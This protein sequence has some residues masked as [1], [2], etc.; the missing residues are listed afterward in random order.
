[1]IEGYWTTTGLQRLLFDESSSFL[2]H[3]ASRKW[4]ET[5]PFYVNVTVIRYCDFTRRDGERYMP[6]LSKLAQIRKSSVLGQYKKQ[7]EFYRNMS[8]KMVMEKLE[9]TFPYL[10]NK[11]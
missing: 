9:E 10:R 6:T 11:R 4:C 1:M 8:E 7:V 5:K 2:G 3:G